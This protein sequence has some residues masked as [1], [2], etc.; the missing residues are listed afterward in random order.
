MCNTLV[1]PENYAAV[2]FL[3]MKAPGLL[4]PF[5]LGCFLLLSA[6]GIGLIRGQ[7]AEEWIRKKGHTWAGAFCLATLFTW[8]FISLSQVSVFLYFNF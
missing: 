4:N 6:L 2:K 1:F 8:S 3:G 7:K 5:F